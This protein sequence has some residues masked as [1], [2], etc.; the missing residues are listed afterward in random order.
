[1]MNPIYMIKKK[2]IDSMIIPFEWQPR[3][4]ICFMMLMI[5]GVS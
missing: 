4:I 2:T 5:L 3:L 1:M